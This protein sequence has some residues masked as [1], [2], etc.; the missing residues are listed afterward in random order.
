MTAPS[1]L[2]PGSLYQ[3]AVPGLVSGP[4]LSD[5]IGGLAQRAEG[6]AR[7]ILVVVDLATN[8]RGVGQQL[9]D[10]YIARF[11]VVERRQIF[12][13]SVVELELAVLHQHERRRADERLGHRTHGDDLIGA[14][15]EAA[16]HVAPAGGVLKDEFA[17]A[18]H[19]ENAAANGVVLHPAA[20]AVH[21][22]VEFRRGH[23]DVLGAGARKRLGGLRGGGPADENCCEG[24]QSKGDVAKR[25]RGAG[26][27]GASGGSRRRGSRSMI[28][29]LT[30]ASQSPQ[31]LLMHSNAPKP[32]NSAW[33]LV[34]AILGSS[35][36]FID[37]TAVNVALPALQSSLHA[38]IADVQWVVEAYA[39]VLAALLLTGGSLGDRYGHRRI[40]AWG[41]LWFALASAWCGLAPTVTQLIVARAVQGAGA[42]LLVP[43]S[44]ALITVSFAPASRGPA[45]GTW[46]AWTAVTSAVGPVLGGW[47][48][49]HAS[50]RWVFAI[51]LPIATLVLGVIYWRIPERAVAVNTSQRLDWAGA[52]LAALGLGGVVYGCLEHS[53]AAAAI[54]GALLI[55]FVAVEAQVAAPMMPLALFRSRTFAGA[56][57]L[58]LFLYA[59]LSGVLLFLPLDLI[60]VQG[61]SATAAGAALLPFILLLVLLSRWS[62]GLVTRIGARAT[63][64]TGTLV[65]SAGFA[66]FAR[67]GVG[68]SYWTTFFPAVVVLGL[69][70]ACSV[71]PLTTTVMGAVSVEHTGA[72]SGINNAVSR[73]AGM[74]AVAVL[75]LVL[76]SDFNKELDRRLAV[77]ELS[78]AVRAEI[79]AQRPL[80]A[81]ARTS[82]AAGRAAIDGA[83]VDGFR[84]VAWIGGFLGLASAAS[85][86]LLLGE[87]KASQGG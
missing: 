73:V 59:A 56:N 14:H 35:L 15:A 69:G 48:V 63:L 52:T 81:A 2:M 70:M 55:A 43:G 87:W 1:A 18:D 83:F 34:A 28:R 37:G 65:A 58:T 36:A 26:V 22:F 16:L 17:A 38:T 27:H 11:R 80:L 32:A 24:E 45:I 10:C 12:G 76:T 54:G 21:G 86:G 82:S 42:A 41:V 57:L 44:L 46:S 53:V 23:A 61:Y 85:A 6:R 84:I 7:A 62:G 66:L 3:Y 8:A 29:S 77:T 47:L 5:G 51:N 50:W 49:E 9:E 64:V 33:V 74:L 4:E 68:G 25:K 72:A 39:L 79:D 75:G 19:D 67:P 13:D 60:Q 40:F 20:H 71:A 30:R 31:T 78:P